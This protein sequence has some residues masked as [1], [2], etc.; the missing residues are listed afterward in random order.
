MVMLPGLAMGLWQC[1]AYIHINPLSQAMSH[2]KRTRKVLNE[3]FTAP[4]YGE[5]L[6]TRS[7]W[8]RSSICA[9]PFLMA[10][11][12]WYAVVTMVTTDVSAV[13]VA[14]LDASSSSRRP[15]VAWSTPAE[16]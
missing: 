6:D 13:A 11:L 12:N 15:R 1:S 7:R 9:I 2:Q 5:A 3:G 14:F 8:F 4:K 16:L 10:S